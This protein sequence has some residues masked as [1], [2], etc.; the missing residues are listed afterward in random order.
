M[1]EKEPYTIVTC[2]YPGSLS[3]KVIEKMKEGY[4]PIGGVYV[5]TTFE[6]N[7]TFGQAMVLNE[8]DE[9]KEKVSRHNV[10]DYIREM[11]IEREE[12]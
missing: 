6:P 10:E 12:R 8:V 4:T 1:S 3:I 11:L 7:T 9:E 5:N 2:T